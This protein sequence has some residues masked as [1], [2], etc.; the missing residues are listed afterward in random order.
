MYYLRHKD[1][2]KVDPNNLING[3][4]LRKITVLVYLNPDLDSI[5]SSDPQ[6]KMGELRL[7][8]P[9][10]IVDVV[11]RMGRAVIFKS[12]V[13]EH[14][15]RPTLGYDRYAVTVWFNQLVSKPSQ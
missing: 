14:E 3:Q 10:K 11:P 8:L 9:K 6:A 15:V 12:E 1:A 5:K 2:F 7:Y 13:L 4:K